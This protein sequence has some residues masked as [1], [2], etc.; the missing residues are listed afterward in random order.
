M[1]AIAFTR[2]SIA[3]GSREC[4]PDDRLRD[5]SRRM[6]PLNRK[7]PLSSRGRCFRSFDQAPDL[8]DR[9]AAAAHLPSGARQASGT[10]GRMDWPVVVRHASYGRAN[11]HCRPRR[12]R[13]CFLPAPELPPPGSACAFAFPLPHPRLPGLSAHIHRVDGVGRHARSSD[14]TYIARRRCGLHF[15]TSSVRR[16]I[17]RKSPRVNQ[18]SRP[19][20]DS[21][22]SCAILFG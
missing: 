11:D 7:M 12:K 19:C 10:A 16:N 17:Q 18:L 13:E 15:V 2:G 20:P 22:L 14:N 3:N 1:N 8:R 5:A 6:K 21:A 9:A 4:A